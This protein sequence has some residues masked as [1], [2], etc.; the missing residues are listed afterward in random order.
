MEVVEIYRNI[1][2]ILRN[3]GA[4]KIYIIKSKTLNYGADL[5]L[6]VEVIADRIDSIDKAIEQIQAACPGVQCLLFDGNDPE[7][8]D[9]LLEAEEEGIQL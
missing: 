8:Y 2:S 5:K 4:S 9:L 6:S 3:A 1:G 7:H